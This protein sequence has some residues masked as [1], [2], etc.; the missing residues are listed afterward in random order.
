[1]WSLPKFLLL[2]VDCDVHY[3]FRS[4]TEFLAPALY[5]AFQTTELIYVYL[6]LKLRLQPLC[7]LLPFFYENKFL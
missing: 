7:C 2:F 5:T 1:M 6:T 4:R 3:L